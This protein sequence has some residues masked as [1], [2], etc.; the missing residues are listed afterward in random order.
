MPAR[1]DSDEHTL[2]L[3]V[4]AMNTHLIA[5]NTLQPEV[6]AMNMY[7]SLRCSNEHLLQLEVIAM[8]THSSQRFMTSHC[9]V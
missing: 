9:P 1:D 5:M 8:N 6:I 7:S 2:Q 4:I 3:E